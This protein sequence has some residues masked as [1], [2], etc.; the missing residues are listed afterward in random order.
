[1][2]DQRAITEKAINALRFL[3]AEAV[4]NARSGHP[5]MPMGAAPMAY[6]LWSR[7]L[8]HNPQDPQW[9]DRDR[10]VLSAGHGSM[11]LYALLHLTGYDL[12]LEDLKQFRRWGSRTP[13]HPEYRCAPGV[14]ITTG[15]LGQGISTAVGL[16][17]AERKLAAEFNR[18]SYTLVDHCTYVIASDGDLMEGVSS[19]ASSL[20][21]HWKL[22]KLIV[23]YDDNGITI[24]G[25][26][27]LS[28]TED[29]LK[30]YRAY[31]WHTLRVEDG[32]DL[33]AISAAIEEAR[34]DL[35]PSLIAVRTH[36]GY[37]TPRQDTSKAHGEPLGAEA[38]QAA[39]A[40]L[41]WPHPP[42]HIPPEV[43][44]HFRQTT[45]AGRQ[46]YE[47]WKTVFAAYQRE[48]PLLA[49]EFIRRTTGDLPAELSWSELR[50]SFSPQEKMATR[51]AS[52]M[53]LER[54]TA[55]IPELVGG[56]ADLAVSTNTRPRG[57]EDFSPE[58]P[59]GRYFHFGVR[60]H[61]MAAIT[62]GLNLHGGYRAYCSTFLVFS[63]YMR[64]AIRLAALMEIPTIFVFT[65]DS[66]AVGEDGPTHQPVEHLMSLRA[67]P[68]LWVVRPMDA[69]ETAYAWQLALQRREGPT[70][71]ILTR[72]A[73]PVLDRAFLYASAEGV[74]RGA[75][76]LAETPDPHV[77][78]VGTGSE[79]HLALA[80][81]EKLLQEGIRARI[82][83][84]PCWEAFEVQPEEYKEAVF[85]PG[86][87]RVAIEAGI[88]L[89]WERY[90][91][92]VI[93]IDRFGA[94]APYPEVY[95][96]LGFGLE[97]VVARIKS[98]LS[99]KCR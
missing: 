18:G 84:M 31:G 93:G 15:P 33:E 54:L 41:D 43:Y 75:Y 29:V 32:E 44:E 20:A 2:N 88:P 48:Y 17:L 1:M 50:P 68:Q 30:R 77:L 45:A 6:I 57:V 73:L 56:S 37:G 71:I 96:R 19:E 86:L 80:A 47:E 26:T 4:E 11:L 64:P 61:A 49:A 92:L 79:V 35:R 24:D 85:L 63:D 12:S 60:E 25:P 83:S 87:P 38:L 21:G 91:D 78:L 95:E 66:I 90:A 28:F 81:K 98:F 16:A 52:G 27:G 40:K 42:F 22:G 99:E 67:I 23:L 10:F 51:A 76:I 46:K 69:Q 59:L 5:G 70:A 55:K 8:K 9:P 34:K 62:N 39:K 58:N 82:I 89:G 94:S 7:F 13:G 3:A 53:V 36:I 14:E 97:D 72:Q 65:H 74:L